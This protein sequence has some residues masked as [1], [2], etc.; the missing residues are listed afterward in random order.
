M[1]A[2]FPGVGVFKHDQA[3]MAA[4]ADERCTMVRYGGM[5]KRT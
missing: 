1:G 5:A 2:A 4:E 3:V